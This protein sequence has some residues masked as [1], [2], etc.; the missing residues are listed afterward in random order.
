[1]GCSFSASHIDMTSSQCTPQRPQTDRQTDKQTDRQRFWVHCWLR[2]ISSVWL[3]F[4]LCCGPFLLAHSVHARMGKRGSEDD[5]LD[6][7]FRERSRPAE[8]Q[9]GDRLLRDPCDGHCRNGSRDRAA[10]ADF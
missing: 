1:M 6:N 2:A 9:A 7:G 10:A 3:L 8:D 4:V 5:G